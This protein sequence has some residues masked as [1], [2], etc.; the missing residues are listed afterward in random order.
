MYTVYIYLVFY[1]FVV[2]L[3][4]SPRRHEEKMTQNFVQST[5]TISHIIFDKLNLKQQTNK[6]KI[7]N[8]TLQNTLPRN[9]T[10]IRKNC[11]GQNEQNGDSYSL[12]K[13]QNYK[14][15]INDKMCL[16]FEK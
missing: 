1:T 9:I 4:V 11:D 13:F 3:A 12:T 7:K 15:K 2:F 16:G 6:T 8:D 5:C 10:R 14:E